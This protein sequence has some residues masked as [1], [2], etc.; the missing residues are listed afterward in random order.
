MNSRERV[1]SALQHRE[2]D[3]IPFDLG[4]TK[5]TGI[6]RKAYLSLA[7]HL[8]EEIGTFEFYDVTQQLAAME[9]CILQRLEVDTRGLMPNVVRK[10]PHF[11][12]IHNIQDDVPPEN[13]VAMWETWRE[14][15]A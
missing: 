7:E 12:A 5:V 1:L 2:P 15:R 14:M 11:G 9:E 6:T 10:A 13:I 3:K 8:E 4:S